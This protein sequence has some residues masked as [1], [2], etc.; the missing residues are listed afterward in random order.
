M[1]PSTPNVGA[2]R[3][4]IEGLTADIPNHERG[5]TQTRKAA[6]RLFPILCVRAPRREPIWFH[7]ALSR[8]SSV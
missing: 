2:F 1:R 7:R 6:K 3:Q 4:P 5:L 8:L